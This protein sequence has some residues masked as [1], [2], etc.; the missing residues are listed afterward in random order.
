MNPPSPQTTQHSQKAVSFVFPRLLWRQ[1]RQILYLFGVQSFSFLIRPKMLLSRL[2]CD[3]ALVVLVLRKWDRS[4]GRSLLSC[5]KEAPAAPPS[6]RTMLPFE[7]C[8][9]SSS[10]GPEESRSQGVWVHQ[11][12]GPLTHQGSSLSWP[13]CLGQDS[14]PL[15]SSVFLWSLAIEDKKPLYVIKEGLQLSLLV[16]N[17]QVIIFS[18]LLSPSP[19]MSIELSNSYPV[20]LALCYFSHTFKQL[21]HLSGWYIFFQQYFTPAHHSAKS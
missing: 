14:N 21:I 18:L 6:R 13:A 1:V 5:R 16:F 7:Q 11:P 10:K 3:L 8:T 17:C 4:E 2:C 15:C 19:P 9:T 12:R 20:P